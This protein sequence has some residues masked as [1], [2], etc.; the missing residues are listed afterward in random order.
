[1]ALVIRKSRP[2]PTR[3]EGMR[4]GHG[5]SARH[6]RQVKG[7]AP[8]TTPD[9]K[10][11]VWRVQEALPG[12]KWQQLPVTQPADDDG[13][14]FFLLPRRPGEVSIESSDGT[15]P[16][17]IETDKH[18]QRFTANSPGETAEMIVKWLQLPGGRARSPGHPR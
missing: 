2:A 14:W 8:S 12:V 16:F 5:E 7:G 15:C 3:G 6:V 9:L 17:L 1:M 11:I 18:D 13:L 4:K 10:S